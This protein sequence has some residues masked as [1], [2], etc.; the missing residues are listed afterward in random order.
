MYPGRQSYLVYKK[1]TKTE[2]AI[3]KNTTQNSLPLLYFKPTSDASDP[4]ALFVKAPQC[5]RWLFYFPV[6]TYARLRAAIPSALNYK[7]SFCRVTNKHTPTTHSSCTRIVTCESNNVINELK[8]LKKKCIWTLHDERT[9]NIRIANAL[10]NHR[11]PTSYTCLYNITIQP[12]S[13]YATRIHVLHVKQEILFQW[14]IE[15][16]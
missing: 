8:H 2:F 13:M 5:C 1:R 6:A 14:R 15:R 7:Q 3:G 12:S 11:M 16:M 4:K 10:Y 9:Q